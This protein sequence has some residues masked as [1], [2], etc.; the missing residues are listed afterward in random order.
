MD[1]GQAAFEKIIC[2]AN[3]IQLYT[4]MIYRGPYIA[5]KISSELI[6]ILKNKGFKNVSEAVGTKNWSWRIDIQNLY[7]L[8][9]Y[10]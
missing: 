4:G 7:S 10:V 6:D 5:S 9:I 3:L 8:I 2:G 1:T